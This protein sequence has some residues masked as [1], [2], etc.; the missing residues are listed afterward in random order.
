[1]ISTQDLRNKEVINIHNGKSLGFVEDIAVDLER[2][3]VEG[4]VIP[5][6]STGLFSFFGKGGEIIIPWNAVRR[7]GEEVL[8]VELGG[9][10]E[11]AFERKDG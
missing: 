4:I 8:L 1:M 9:E 11:L 2:G 10:N 6:Q 5:Q 3:I 7:V